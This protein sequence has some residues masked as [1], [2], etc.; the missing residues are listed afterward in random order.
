[1]VN[2]PTLQSGQLI[3]VFLYLRPKRLMAVTRIK[4]SLICQANNHWTSPKF[5]GQSLKEI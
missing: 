4:I 3:P 5:A 1:M 2:I